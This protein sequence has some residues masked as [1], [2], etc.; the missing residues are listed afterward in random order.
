MEIKLGEEI[1]DREW[2][3]GLILHPTNMNL[4]FNSRIFALWWHFMFFFPIFISKGD[5][6]N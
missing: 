4:H 2:H 6:V 3:D 5:I 1:F